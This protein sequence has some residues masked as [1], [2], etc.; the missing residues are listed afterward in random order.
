[1]LKKTFTG[2][3]LLS[4]LWAGSCKDSDEEVQ[5][6]VKNIQV[7]GMEEG[8]EVWNTAALSVTAENQEGIQ[9]I[10]FY[11]G[12]ESIASDKTAPYEFSWNTREYEDGEYTV[13]MVVVTTGGKTVEKTLAVQVKNTLLELAVEDGFLSSQDKEYFV[14]ISDTTGNVLHYQKIQNGETY[15]IL[16]PETFNDAVFDVTIVYEDMGN[17]VVLRLN[18]TLSLPRGFHFPLKDN[19]VHST[20]VTLNYINASPEME[21]YRLTTNNMQTSIGQSQ[22]TGELMIEIKGAESSLYVWGQNQEGKYFSHLFESIKPGQENIIDLSKVN[23]ESEVVDGNFPEDKLLDGA[24]MYGWI[25]SEKYELSAYKYDTEQKTYSY[26]QHPEAIFDRM[27]LDY[28]FDFGDITIFH[29][30]SPGPK[31]SFP[32]IEGAKASGEVK[33]IYEFTYQAEG[34][35]DFVDMFISNSTYKYLWYCSGPKERNHI[36]PIDFPEEIKNKIPEDTE[37]SRYDIIL[38]E[39]PEHNGYLDAVKT[40]LLDI[41]YRKERVQME[42]NLLDK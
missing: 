25:G 9:Q 28:S 5:I 12:D 17:G 30:N 36:R 4:G 11:V 13:K 2:L 8:A 6:D 26:I 15:S 39:L 33:S 22:P 35:F 34:D 41:R 20:D 10:D 3:L 42:Y 40:D 21:W 27:G 14:V 18:S 23:T 7:T 29:D 32:V 31:P 38:T 37:V 1:M 24:Y 19:S 16:S